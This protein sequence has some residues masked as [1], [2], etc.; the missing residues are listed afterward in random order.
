MTRRVPQYVDS[1]Q[2]KEQSNEDAFHFFLVQDSACA[3]SL[4]DVSSDSV[5]LVAGS[6]GRG[7]GVGLYVLPRCLRPGEAGGT[8]KTR[9][10]AEVRGARTKEKVGHS[11]RDD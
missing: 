4:A 5:R 1:G 6:I 7:R 2:S 10:M 8:Q 11:C 3:L 9:F